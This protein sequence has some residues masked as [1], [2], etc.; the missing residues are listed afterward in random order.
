LRTSGSTTLISMR[1]SARRLATE[2][3]EQMSAKIRWSSSQTAVVPF[4]EEIGR[5]V[6]ADRGDEAELLFLDHAFHVVG[7]DAHRQASAG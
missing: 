5:S 4:G 1:G 3:G 6:L 2:A 7:E